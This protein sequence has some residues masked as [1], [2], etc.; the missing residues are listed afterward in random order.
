MSAEEPFCQSLVVTTSQVLAS[1]CAFPHQGSDRTGQAEVNLVC[2]EVSRVK[3]RR[4]SSR[5]VQEA[6]SSRAGFD[7]RCSSSGDRSRLSKYLCWVWQCWWSGK[8]QIAIDVY[9]IASN[10]GVVRQIV[11]DLAAA[12]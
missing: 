2:S 4:V 11:I 6:Y 3:F 7:C 9:Q 8:R 1:Q 12:G 5:Y 10:Q